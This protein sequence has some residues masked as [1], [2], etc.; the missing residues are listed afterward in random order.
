VF[1][2]RFRRKRLCKR[3]ENNTK[4]KDTTNDFSSRTRTRTWVSRTR[5]RTRTWAPRTRTRT[6]NL[7]LRTPYWQG[8]GQGKQLWLYL[9]TWLLRLHL[10]ILLDWLI[11]YHIRVVDVVVA[12]RRCKQRRTRRYYCVLVICILCIL[13]VALGFGIPFGLAMTRPKSGR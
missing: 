8:P 9:L 6:L 5:T 3:H 1:G 12:V 13:G 7:S 2:S 4:N 10:D 11:K